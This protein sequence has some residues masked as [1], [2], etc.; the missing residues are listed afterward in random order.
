MAKTWDQITTILNEAKFKLP[1]GQKEVKKSTEKVGSKTLD[2]RFG[3]D[4]RGKIH[5]YVNT[6]S[7]GDPYRNMK[8]AEKEMKNIKMVMKQMNEEDISLEEILGVINET[9]I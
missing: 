1:S 9:N 7:M 2:I 3:E 8:E 5:V 6:V 4:K